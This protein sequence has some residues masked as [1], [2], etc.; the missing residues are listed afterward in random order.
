MKQILE[1]GKIQELL[2]DGGGRGW[3][4][5][6]HL[7][8]Y[9]NKKYMLRKAQTLKRA[10][11]YEQ[12]SK[13][14]EKF[15]FLPKFLGR[16]GKNVIYEYIEGRDL[17]KK[18]SLKSIK[19]IGKISAYINKIKITVREAMEGRIKKQI[20][21]ATTGKFK[22]L[23]KKVKP[24]LTK[25]KSEKVKKLYFYLKRKSKPI[26][27]LDLN[28]ATPSNFRLRKGKVYF[29]D[30]ESIKPRIRGYSI[31]KA[32]TKWFQTKKQRK[33]FLEGYKL[34][35][36]IK[37]LNKYYL[38][39]IYLN[40]LIQEVNYTC[41]YGKKYKPKYKT[42]LEFLDELLTKYQKEILE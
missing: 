35:S 5:E 22:K 26:I 28:D 18:E 17:Q 37:F 41:R 16:Y 24:L 27:R 25:E 36:S 4:K 15:G 20:K 21:E 34:V 38:D 12:I 7:L 10:K 11:T 13:K 19:Q 3:S 14:L 8:I 32:F 23:K 2:S 29:V 42:R 1:K 6:A 9:D 39:F 40:Y 33:V 31:G 30:I